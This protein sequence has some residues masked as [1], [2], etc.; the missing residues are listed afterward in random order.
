MSD[1]IGP[2]IARCVYGGIA[3]LFPPRNEAKIFEAADRAGATGC[4]EQLVAGSLFYAS[5]KN[6]AYIA[7]KSPSLR[8]RTLSSRFKKHL[9]WIPLSTFSNETLNR[10]R[11]FHVLNGTKVRSWASR[12]IGDEL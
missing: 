3:L 12:F 8:L 6:I 10:L 4:A 7:A 1:L 11:R 9:V 5:E 2:G